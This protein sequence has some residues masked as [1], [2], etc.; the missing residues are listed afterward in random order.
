MALAQRPRHGHRRDGIG[1][2]LDL[3]IVGQ[4]QRVQNGLVQHSFEAA[5]VAGIA[6]RDPFGE[7]DFEGN[8]AIFQLQQEIDLPTV[9]SAQVMEGDGKPA[10]SRSMAEPQR[11]ERSG[12]CTAEGRVRI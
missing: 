11:R 6:R 10:V 2:R 5:K 7:L 8:V 1:Q 12:L 4:H 9:G 3:C